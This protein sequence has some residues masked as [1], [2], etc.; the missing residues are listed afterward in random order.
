MIFPPI[1]PIPFLYAETH[2]RFKYFFSFLKKSEPEILADI[3][4]RLDPDAA[5]PVLVLVKDSHRYPLQKFGVRIEVRWEGRTLATIEKELAAPIEE[6][7]WWQIIVVSFAGELANVFGFLD[8]HTHFHYSVGG[9]ER[10]CKNDNYRSSSKKSLRVYRSAH[11]LPSVDGWVQGDTHIH[12][13]YTD[14]QVEFGS[15][16]TPSVELSKA[17]GLSFFCVTDHSYDLDDR[18]DNYLVNDPGIPKWKAEQKE[19]DGI[20]SSQSDFV[21]VRGEEVSCFNRA[22]RNI[23]L[24]LWG[25]KSFFKG[26][27]DSA[28]R[29]LRT[30]AE[31]TIADVLSQKEK[32]VVAYAGHPTERAP[33]FQWLL[34]RRGEWGI[35]DMSE[36]GLAGIQI[37]NGEA[38]EAFFRG[39]ECWTTLLL[40]GR[41]IFISAGNDAHGNFNRFKQIGI[42]FF[43]IRESQHQLFGKMR[44]AAGCAPL[45][46][47]SLLESFRD[48]RTVITNGPMVVPELVNERGDVAAPGQSIGGTRFQLHLLGSSSEEFGSFREL[49]VILG[50]VGF[51][52]EQVTTK[53][54]SGVSSSLD[55]NMNIDVPHRQTPLYV[56]VELF[57][58]K[59]VHDDGNGFCYTNPIWIRPQ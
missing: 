29:W 4:Y 47:M 26:S 9:K 8:I 2:Y 25:T 22:H 35:D 55:L 23:H 24:L 39:L 59:G 38:N 45:S 43:T 5:L 34:I 16:I 30:K 51:E 50:I 54:L 18:V 36:E 49:R 56:R 21:V 44:T 57:T 41:R 32:A 15:P 20:N 3:P 53:R 12:S 6:P 42:P 40:R 27:G 48:G 58:E 52:R 7:L 17:M 31:H 14:D 28:E 1:I 33:F 37:L 10:S 11:E 19:I 13:S 46:E